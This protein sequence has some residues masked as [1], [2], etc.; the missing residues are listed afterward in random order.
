LRLGQICFAAPDIDTRQF[1]DQLGR[2]ADLAERV[3]LAVN[4]NDSALAWA[5]RFNRSGSRAGRPNP[6]ELSVEQ[7]EFRVDATRR[8]N[9]DLIK[10]D[11]NDIPN[12]PLRSHAFWYDDPWVS[13]DIL[14]MFLL[15][16]K[17]QQ[18]GLEPQVRVDGVKI[19]TFPPDYDA[20]VSTL[21]RDADLA[22]S[23]PRP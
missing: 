14:A 20:R 1:V 16:A 23:E 11:P 2:Y 17:P 13:S 15:N 9:F 21:M 6:T 8:L 12:L 19:W 7:T 3:S 22:V 4:L 5:E 18:R 10:V